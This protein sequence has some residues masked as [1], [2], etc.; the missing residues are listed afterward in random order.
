MTV[1]SPA[2]LLIPCPIPLGPFTRPRLVDA[3]AMLTD[4]T[5]RP[6]TVLGWCRDRTGNRPA[7]YVWLDIAGHGEG[8][9][10]YEPR[11]LRRI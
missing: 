9:Y 7:W 6:A 1:T 3:Q 2:P 10:H 4:R 5:W 11:I 8:W